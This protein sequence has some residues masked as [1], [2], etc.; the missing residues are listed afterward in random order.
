MPVSINL[1]LKLEAQLRREVH[2]LDQMAKEALLV[3]LYRRGAITHHELSE[4]LG[5]E[6][7]RVEELLS[8]YGVVEDLPS[9]ESV[10]QEAA[11]LG[12]RLAR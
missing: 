4:S 10:L 2:D 5:M 8:R 1:P 3:D 11:E 12:S 9:A 6:R 7:F